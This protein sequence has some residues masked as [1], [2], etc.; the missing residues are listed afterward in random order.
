[1]IV[2]VASGLSLT[3]ADVDYCRGKARVLVVNDNYHKAPW[4]DWLYACDY[5]WW[6]HKA[7]FGEK[8]NHELT[9]EI[10]PGQRWMMSDAGKNVWGIKELK[11][12]IGGGLCRDKDYVSWGGPNDEGGNSGHQ[13][14]NLA[15]HLRDP[16]EPIA[17]LGFDMGAT[18]CEHWFGQHPETLGNP[19]PHRFK[20]WVEYFR[21]IAADLAKEGVTVINCTRTTALDCFKQL[22]IEDV[23]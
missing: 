9:A 7:L 6:G 4:A 18:G 23:I 10:F 1:M 20:I 19:L 11:G 21:L 2:V 13:A 12:R 22:T 5:A 8:R 17:L 14:L 16:D 15:Y 3:Q